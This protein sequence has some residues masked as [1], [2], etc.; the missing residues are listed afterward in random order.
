MA[1]WALPLSL[2]LSLFLLLMLL[3]ASIMG[4]GL[5]FLGRYQVYRP[6]EDLQTCRYTSQ[7]TPS[8]TCKHG[9]RYLP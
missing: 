3:Q 8:H 2:S 5:M 7:Y 6:P 1:V 4:L 9:P